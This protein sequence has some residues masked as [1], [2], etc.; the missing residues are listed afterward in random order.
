MKTNMKIM[1]IALVM[2]SIM[3]SSFTFADTEGFGAAGATLDSSYTLEE[4]LIYAIQD[5][6][7]A[8]AE[9]E[10]IMDA[11]DVTRPF[12]NIMKSEETH[13]TLLEP[14]F[15]AYGYEM[16]ADTS[17]IYTHLPSTLNETYAIGVAAEISNIAM[18]EKFLSG[19]LPDD[20]R[21]VFERLMNASKNHLKAFERGVSRLEAPTARRGGNS[22]RFSRR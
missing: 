8:R 6:Y 7:L 14:L 13:I 12:S 11:F 1:V 17:G 4:M 15:E 20:V 3:T 10:A 18:Y 5:E 22:A 9:Y 19:E 2:M 21:D 16:P